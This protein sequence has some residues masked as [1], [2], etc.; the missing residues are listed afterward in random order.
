MSR[1]CSEGTAF[2]C[3][4]STITCVLTRFKVR[5]PWALWGFYR[6]FRR[7]RNAARR[8][9]GLLTCAFLIENS[10]TCYTFSLWANDAAIRDFNTRV[11]EHVAA[12]NGSFRNLHWQSTGPELWSAQFQL[13]ALSRYNHRWPGLD[14]GEL[15]PPEEAQGERRDVA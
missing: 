4:D 8:I 14:L 10:R 12:A 5:S 11:P 13:A 15:V 2:E 1:R 9:P 7:V 6:S 3:I